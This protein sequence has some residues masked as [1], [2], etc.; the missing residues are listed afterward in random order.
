KYDEAA[1]SMIALLKYGGGFPWNRLGNL[2]NCLGI[3]LPPSTQWDIVQDASQA[4]EPAF[5]ELQRQAAQGQVLHNDDTA[6]TILERM[7]KRREAFLRRRSD[8]PQAQDPDRTGLFTSGILSRT[9]Q[10]R[11]ALF[12]TGAKHAG[13]NLTAVL[14][15]RERRRRR[16]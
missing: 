14:Q 10:W 13:E 9:K 1:S 16:P 2:Q 4:C 6:M 15:A 8:E 5:E 12:F 11:I 3:P 7:G